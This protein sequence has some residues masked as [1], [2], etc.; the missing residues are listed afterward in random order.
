M[1]G[2]R[3][4]LA[5]LA[6]LALLAAA[7]GGG[8][9]EAPSSTPES[10]AA[11]AGAEVA[12][13]FDRALLAAFAPLPEVMASTSNP[14]TDAKVRLGRMLYHDERFS[15]ASDISCASCHQ[16]D[17]FGVDSKPF[18]PGHEGQL[19]GR[20]SPTVYNAAG[21]LSQFWDGRAADVEEQAKGPVLNPVEMA[22]PSADLVLARIRAIPGYGEAF[23]TAFPGETDPVTYDNFGK[24]IG[25]FERELVTPG[26]WDAFLGGDDTAL[27]A[28]EQ[29]GFR[30][31]VASGCTACHAGPYVGGQMYQKLGLVL[32]WPDLKDAG[33]YEATKNEADR[34]FFKVPSLRNVAKTGPYFHDGSVASLDEAIRLMAEHQMGRDLDAA[35][36]KSIRTFLEALTGEP[37]AGLVARPTLPPTGPGGLPQTS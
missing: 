30:D 15:L 34:S 26:R 31:F 18:S 11:P 33:R 5:L 14:G 9:A 37:P 8:G 4:N 25:A 24:A 10:A 35:T 3:L 19:G 32:P 1:N 6:I 12:P 17:N 20:N 22:M 36:V 27:T 2:I 7:C 13:A 28:K 21:H 16:L 23:A 29:A